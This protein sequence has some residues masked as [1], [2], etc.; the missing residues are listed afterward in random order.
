MNRRNAL[1]GLGAIA[2]GGGALFGSGAFSTVEAERNVSI[3]AADDNNANLQFSVDDGSSAIA[4]SSGDTI[5]I[6]GQNLNLEA[7]TTVNQVL[8]ITVSSAAN[9]SYDLDILGDFGGSSVTLADGNADKSASGADMQFVANDGASSG[10]ADGSGGYTGVSAGSSVVYDIVF[11]LR[12]DS[13]TG[14]PSV[15]F[16]NNTIVVEAI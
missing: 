7:V 5:A 13:G 9:G 14:D 2:T 15:P 12:D 1:L 4:T 16:P 10:T 6:D 8:T 3:S 11:N